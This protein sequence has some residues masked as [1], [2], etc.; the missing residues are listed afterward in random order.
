MTEPTKICSR[1][2]QDLP[3]SAYNLH[4][5]EQYS[6]NGA[7]ENRLGKPRGYC[8]QCDTIYARERRQR[9]RQARET[10]RHLDAQTQRNARRAQ[11]PDRS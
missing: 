11:T 10:R 2:K 7:S 9:L 4:T 8:K 6:D 1:C 5:K 3:W